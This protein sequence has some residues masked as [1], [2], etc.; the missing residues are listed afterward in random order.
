MSMIL[1]SAEIFD[2]KDWIDTFFKKNERE[3]SVLFHSEDVLQPKII[4][5]VCSRFIQFINHM[6]I[7]Y[8]FLPCFF[9]YI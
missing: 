4:A 8:L 7:Y 6:H 5:E 2:F 3:N 1:S 9:M